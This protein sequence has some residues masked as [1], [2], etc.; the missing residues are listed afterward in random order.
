MPGLRCI[1]NELSPKVQKASI[2]SITDEPEVNIFP[3]GRGEGQSCNGQIG[4][5][6]LGWV[7]YQCERANTSRRLAGLLNRDSVRGFYKKR[8]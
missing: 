7:V 1:K 3:R 5:L 8:L 6:T 4:V 2:L